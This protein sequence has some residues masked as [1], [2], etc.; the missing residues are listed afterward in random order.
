M[1]SLRVTLRAAPL[2]NRFLGYIVTEILTDYAKS[3]L[4]KEI[5]TF[6]EIL[7]MIFSFN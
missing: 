6:L 4:G 1:G 3:D 7:T 2:A 5:T